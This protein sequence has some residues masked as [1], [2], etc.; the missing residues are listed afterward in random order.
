MRGLYMLNCP[1]CTEEMSKGYDG[2]WRCQTCPATWIIR[3]YC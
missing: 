2:V 1:G 3:R